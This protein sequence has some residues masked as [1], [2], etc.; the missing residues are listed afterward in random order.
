[1]GPMRRM[2][3][4]VPLGRADLVDLAVRGGVRALGA[5]AAVLVAVPAL[6]AGQTIVEMPGRKD[7]RDDRRDVRVECRPNN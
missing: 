2:G 7:G 1:M 3:R 5:P 4:L 6:L